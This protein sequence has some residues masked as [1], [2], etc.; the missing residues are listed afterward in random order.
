[1]SVR[2]CVR[3]V[4]VTGRALSVQGIGAWMSV[5]SWGL[6]DV[7][8]MDLAVSCSVFTLSSISRMCSPQAMQ[9]SG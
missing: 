4:V 8:D 7:E 1:M 9:V 5:S 6:M 2:R 3:P